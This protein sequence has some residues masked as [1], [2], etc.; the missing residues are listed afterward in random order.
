MFITPLQQWASLPQMSEVSGIGAVTGRK[1]AADSGV[2]IA[3]QEGIQAFKSI[4]DE[5]VNNVRI[6]EDALAKEQYLL[7]TG[8]TDNPHAS[9]IAASEAQLT[10]S[11]LVALR[12]KTMEAYNEIMRLTL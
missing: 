4:F 12:T 10:V 6:K 2:A 7:A 9:G 8:Q 5:A 3:G 11:M 1:N